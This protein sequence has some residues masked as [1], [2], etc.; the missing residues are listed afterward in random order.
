MF[1]C[2]T[3]S[4]TNHTKS[5]Y[6]QLSV[7]FSTFA[8]FH[9]ALISTASGRVIFCK[10]EFSTPIDF[11]ISSSCFSRAIAIISPR[12]IL[13]RSVPWCLPC[14]CLMLQIFNVCP[15]G[16]ENQLHHI[17]DLS[18]G[19]DACRVRSGLAPQILSAI[20]NLTIPLLLQIHPKNIAAANQIPWG[21]T[22]T[23]TQNGQLE[24]RMKRPCRYTSPKFA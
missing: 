18:F 21:K 9:A 7:K 2:S 14:D 20:R 13:G 12:K 8:L 22:I 10:F 15:W 5:I 24:T 3:R 23:C 16:I 1:N 17:R 19:H 4:V 11:M 6:F